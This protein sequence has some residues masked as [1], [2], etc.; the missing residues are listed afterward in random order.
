MAV[1]LAGDGDKLLGEGSQ[2][3]EILPEPPSMM[4]A[5]ALIPSKFGKTPTHPI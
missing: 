1:G 5:L 4:T 2:G 3:A